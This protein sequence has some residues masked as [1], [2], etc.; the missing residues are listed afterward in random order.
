MKTMKQK[1][2]T[3]LKN[4]FLRFK[5][6]AQ[7]TFIGLGIASTI[8]F[9]IR[10]IPKPTRATYPCMRA[11]APIMSGFIIYLSGL[12]L[13]LFAFKK[14]IFHFQKSKLILGGVLTIIAVTVGIGI[15]HSVSSGSETSLYAAAPEQFEPNKPVGVAQG[16]FPGRV[17]WARDPDATTKYYSAPSYNLSNNDSAIINRMTQQTIRSLTG[18]N[19]L[20]EAWD[21][22]FKS[23]NEKKGKGDSGYQAGQKVFIKINCNSAWG[24]PAVTGTEFNIYGSGLGRAL[25]EDY[26]FK[27]NAQSYG[28]FEGNAYTMLS[29]I[30]QLVNKAGVPQENIS[31]GDPMR[32]IHKYTYDILHNAFPNVHYLGHTS[33]YERTLVAPSKDTLV[34]FSD[35]GKVLR[36]YAGKALV[37]INLYSVVEEADYIINLA[38]LKAHSMQGVTSLAKN[39][40]G[41]TARI[42][43]IEMH[44]GIVSPNGTGTGRA[45]GSYRVLVDLMGNKH[46][47]GKTMLFFV[48]ATFF[49][50]DAY[51][52]PIRLK[53]PPFNGD[54]PSSVVASQ[55][56]VAAESVCYDILA[57]QY[58]SSCGFPWITMKGIC[59]HLQQA[60]DPTSWPA[61]ITYSPNHDGIPMQSLGAYEHWNNVTDQQYSRNLGSGNGIELIKLGPI[62]DLIAAPVQLTVKS[63][64][65]SEIKIIWKDD[66]DK[67]EGYIIESSKGDSLHYSQVGVVN[68]DSV[69]FIFNGTEG[70]TKYYFRVKA[71]KGSFTSGNSNEVSAMTYSTSV[72]SPK[73]N[74]MNSFSVV[75]ETNAI[76]V[77]F[78]NDIKGPVSLTVYD[79]SGKK[80]A[81][82]EFIKP[83][84]QKEEMIAMNG[85]K[86]LFIISLNVDGKSISKKFL[87]Q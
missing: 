5:I 45:A 50:P 40:F 70:N 12:F 28:T 38:A 20:T 72:V 85:E 76:K 3:N 1:S 10:V 26:S 15:N 73:S 68:K 14:A 9:L 34:Y 59:E 62:D 6:P 37:G 11:A 18:K 47:G 81:S 22:L 63:F 79:S 75:P 33:T 25:N 56:G 71:Y 43:A 83:T 60:A 13:S 69:G 31:I 65:S 30:D 52:L 4:H 74:L 23:F 87:L 86:G 17:V 67:E 46:L 77:T 84:F 16:I 27:K 66:S 64:S 53:N 2:L 8:W 54:W 44:N 61:G 21:L 55:D 58:S 29:I 36:N 51:G 48:D 49:C 7:I 42:W 57:S 39:Y 41:A 35:N 80:I 24:H 78:N 32:D 19:D 82:K